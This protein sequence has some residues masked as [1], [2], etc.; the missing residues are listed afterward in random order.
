MK[1]DGNQ[2]EF[3]LMFS[4]VIKMTNAAKLLVVRKLIKL[5]HRGYYMEKL[6]TS[7]SSLEDLGQKRLDG[8][9]KGK[10]YKS[11]GCLPPVLDWTVG[12]SLWFS[13]LGVRA[14]DLL[15]IVDSDHSFNQVIS[16]LTMSGKS[17]SK[18]YGLSVWDAMEVRESM[19]ALTVR[20]LA[21]QGCD[22]NLVR[23]GGRNVLFEFKDKNVSYGLMDAGVRV[24]CFDDEGNNPIHFAILRGKTFMLDAL[25]SHPAGQQ[26]VNI[27]NRQGLSPYHLSLRLS[28]PL[29][30]DA[31][32]KAGAD[33]HRPITYKALRDELAVLLQR[34]EDN[35]RKQEWVTALQA[36]LC[37][38]PNGRRH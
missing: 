23:D 27:C 7:I 3:N 14:L 34:E 13:D 22:I 21:S 35:Y 15:K 28:S 31:L 20:A 32:I 8:L 25:M 10:Y 26:S 4:L 18:D 16:Y 12:V 6:L 38:T 36:A 2:A 33:N 5:A 37:L 30:R 24:D 1:D 29:V 17:L 19:I 11:G 9:L